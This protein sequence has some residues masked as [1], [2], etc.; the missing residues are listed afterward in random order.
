MQVND[1]DKIGQGRVWTG[2]QGKSNGIVDEYGGLDRAVEVAKELAGLPKDKGVRR[3]I[4]PYPRTIIQQWLGSG[5]DD[6][7]TSE[8]PQLKQ[9]RAVYAI[10]PEDARRAFRYAAL[11]D[12]MKSGD[13]VYLM[14]FDLRIK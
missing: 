2:A 5:N 12:K 6:S 11:L 9:Q 4:F 3:V 10:L 13:A 8:S 14:P 1:V 7:E